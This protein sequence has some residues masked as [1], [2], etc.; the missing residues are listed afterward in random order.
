MKFTFTDEALIA[1]LNETNGSAAKAAV[2]LGVHVRTVE[3]RRALLAKQ[4]YAPEQGLIH[5]YP[6]GFNLGKVTIQRNA[7][8]EIE[9]TWERM[10]ATDE[11]KLIAI[12]HAAEAMLADLPRVKP[13][14]FSGLVR[15]DLLAVYPIGDPHVGMYSWHEET[16]EDWDLHLAE[17]V[18]CDAMDTLVQAMPHTKVGLVI[19]LGDLFHYDSMEAKTPRSGHLVDA[20]SRYGKMIRVGVQLM[21]RCIESALERHETVHVI[22]AQGNHDETGAM[23]LSMALSLAYENE[24]RVKIDM[25]PSVFNYFRWGKVL[26]GVHHGHSCKPAA[27]PGVMATDR[28]KDWGDTDWRYWL[29]GHVH[30]ESKK[31]FPGVSVESFNTLAAKDAYALKGGWRSARTLQGIVYHNVHGEIARSRVNVNMVGK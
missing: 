24:P 18:H 13:K 23:W 19:N 1:A 9:R 12:R 8:G 11:L 10:C 14:K 2:S 17:Q 4:G 21:R 7:D 25:S 26:L 16:G 3:R 29:M 20:D 31:E 28:A 22:N 15:D 6:E 5:K 30:H 27:L